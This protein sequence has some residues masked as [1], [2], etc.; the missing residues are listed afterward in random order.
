MI[1]RDALN[2]RWLAG[3]FRRGAI[4]AAAVSSLRLYGSEISCIGWNTDDSRRRPATGPRHPGT[5]PGSSSVVRGAGTRL[6][7][8]VSEG[9]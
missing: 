5:T 7:R 1:V 3:R 4:T 6:G 8:S 9:R 2:D